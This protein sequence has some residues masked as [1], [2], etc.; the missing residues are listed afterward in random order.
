ML[1]V[2]NVDL[3]AVLEGSPNETSDVEPPSNSLEHA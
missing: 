2:L 3:S 1:G